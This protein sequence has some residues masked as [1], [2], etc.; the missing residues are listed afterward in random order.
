M[1]A[2]PVAAPAAKRPDEP[3]SALGGMTPLGGEIMTVTTTARPDE[4]LKETPLI[5]R[6]MAR[7]ELGAVAG[8]ILVLFFFAVV[9]GRS[10]MFSMLG[11]VTFLDV[12]AQLG[13]IAIM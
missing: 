11:V 3:A 2:S 9:S 8:T 12:S 13:I 7:P 4:R 10:G 6:L 1:P 5:R